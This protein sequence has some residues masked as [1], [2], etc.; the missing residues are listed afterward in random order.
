MTRQRGLSMSVLL[1]SG[2]GGGN[3]AS[4]AFIR[5]VE[6]TEYGGRNIVSKRGRGRLR[7][8]NPHNSDVPPMRILGTCILF[9]IFPPVDGIFA[10]SVRVVEGLP[11]GLVLGTAFMRYHGSSLLFAGPGSGHFKPN[12]H[13]SLVPLLPW[14]Y[15][16]Q[17]RKRS[18]GTYEREEGDLQVQEEISYFSPAQWIPSEDQ[19]PA[20]RPS[21]KEAM[22]AL[23]LGATAWKD[24]GTIQLPVLITCT[25][26]IP[27]GMSVDLNVR[28]TGFTPYLTTLLL[29]FPVASFD[30]DEDI[31]PGVRKGVQWWN[32]QATLKVKVVNKTHKKVVV[33]E[34]IQVAKA[35][36]VNRDDVERMLLLPELIQGNPSSDPQPVKV[37][38]EPTK[39][40]SD[41]ESAP[42]GEQG[43]YRSGSLKLTKGGGR[44]SDVGNARKLQLQSNTCGAPQTTTAT[45]R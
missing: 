19:T 11:F 16:N 26:D 25:A 37:P 21:E 44:H 31:S 4:A 27:G 28:V 12:P 10:A 33:Q 45:P 15:P 32:P 43:S 7:A 1:D 6:R 5:G 35:F 14:T 41:P 40:A 30:L 8:A 20:F 29:V 39:K 2:A 34:G 24:K 13:S 23:D 3:Y 36:A 42:A 9:I 22:E 18:D 38:P 17:G